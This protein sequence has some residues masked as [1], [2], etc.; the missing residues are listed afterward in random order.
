MFFIFL[1]FIVFSKIGMV[2]GGICCG[3]IADKWQCHRKIVT[4][5]CLIS[6]AAITTQPVVSVYY[7]N[8]ETNQCPSPSIIKVTQ[9]INDVKSPDIIINSTSKFPAKCSNRSDTIKSMKHCNCTNNTTDITKENLNK[10]KRNHS[11]NKTL[12]IIMFIINFCFAFGEG[13]SIAFIDSGTL[14]RLQLAKENRPIRYG[15]QRM[16]SA[17]GAIFGILVSNLSDD[18]F[19]RT[20]KISCYAGIFITYGIYTLLYWVSVI[21]SY[22]GLSFRE[23]DREAGNDGSTTPLSKEAFGEMNERC[24]NNNVEL[25]NSSSSKSVNFSTILI[26]TLFRPDILFFYFTT[27]VS[28][29][30]FSQSISFLF[31]YLKEMGAP[32]ILLTL[33]IVIPAFGSAVCFSYAHKMIQFLGGKWRTISFTFLVYFLRYLGISLIQNPWLV[34]IFQLVHFLSVDLFLVAGVLYLKETSPL[35][36][37]TTLVSIFNT[38]YFGL[39]PLVG[40][41]ISG[42]IYQLYGGRALFRYTAVLSIAWFCVLFV[43][44]LFK[45]RRN[46]KTVKILVTESMGASNENLTEKPLR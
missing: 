28:G 21:L 8:P 23:E 9:S 31:V 37:V 39:G 22:R 15:R 38:M 13:S 3:M 45:E 36:V 42:V 17:M 32:S 27:L 41:S 18:F 20:T 4:L 34:F 16:F 12:Y 19:P 46:L 43:Y 25:K 11:D 24:N 10:E 1:F 35:P 44:I 29:L 30:Q 40:S 14:R 33:S 2:L 5:V 6:L 7:G 26:K